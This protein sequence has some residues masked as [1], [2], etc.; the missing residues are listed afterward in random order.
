MLMYLKINFF[1]WEIED[2]AF[3]HRN[4][5]L[6]HNWDPTPWNQFSLVLI[7]CILICHL[8]QTLQILLLKY[9]SANIIA[10]SWLTLSFLTL[11]VHIVVLC[12]EISHS[13]KNAK[14]DWQVIV[15]MG[16]VQSSLLFLTPCSSGTE[17]M[18]S[19]SLWQMS[20]VSF[21][22]GEAVSKYITNHQF[23]TH[24]TAAGLGLC[25]MRW[26][27]FSSHLS[28]AWNSPGMSKDTSRCRCAFEM[29]LKPLAWAHSVFFVTY[30]AMPRCPS[31]V[32]WFTQ[33]FLERQ[34]VVVP[35]YDLWDYSELCSMPG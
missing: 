8:G 11:C 6:L 10:F 22:L 18:T 13:N 32:F 12:S 7:R 30:T 23:S 20:P 26:I 35:D 17:C 27:P 19:Q 14:M 1:L 29:A 24:L 5:V 34:D 33:V 2:T 31:N 16:L 21:T 3:H 15:V 9:I 25:R 4:N 28:N